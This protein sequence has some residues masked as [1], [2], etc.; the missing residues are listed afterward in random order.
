MPPKKKISLN[1]EATKVDENQDQES[2]LRRS[3]RQRSAP[4]KPE[5]YEDQNSSSKTAKVQN[6]DKTKSKPT[7]QV[8]SSENKNKE[9]SKT[10]SKTTAKVNAKAAA[11]AKNNDVDLEV[12]TKGAAPKPVGKGRGR[13][14]KGAP[15][16]NGSEEHKTGQEVAD[17]NSNLKSTEEPNTENQ[18]SIE[19]KNDTEPMLIETSESKDQEADN[20]GETNHSVVDDQITKDKLDEDVNGEETNAGKKL[21]T[22]TNGDK[23]ETLPLKEGEVDDAMIVQD[24]LKVLTKEVVYDKYIETTNSNDPGA[25][26][27]TEYMEYMFT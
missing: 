10:S 21:K 3:T 8:K 4:K 2:S 13:A 20:K 9:G 16:I 26:N 19:N 7:D 23:G 11:K 12:Q 17:A 18:P 1:E 22:D 14:A 27:V 5:G 15:K 24:E 6:Q 25:K